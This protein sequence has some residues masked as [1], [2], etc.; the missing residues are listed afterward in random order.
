[1]RKKRI[2]KIIL[3]LFFV[4]IVLGVLAAKWYS[5]PVTQYTTTTLCSQDGEEINVIFDF[6]W[7]RHLFSP[8]E[9]QGTVTVGDKVYDYVSMNYNYTFLDKFLKKFDP[10]PDFN[11]AVASNTQKWWFD[12]DFLTVYHAGKN[13]YKN[14]SDYICICTYLP[15][16]HSGTFY[17]GPAKTADQAEKIWQNIWEENFKTNYTTTFPVFSGGIL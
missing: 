1:M 12:G 15:G 10:N 4:G 17:F 5:A 8:T 2:R 11:F 7:Q 14:D 6:V 3:T 16:E 13:L 9:L